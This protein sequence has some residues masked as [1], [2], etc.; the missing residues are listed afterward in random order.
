MRNRPAR[1]LIFLAL[2]AAALPLAA[3]SRRGFSLAVVVD[4]CEVP[5]YEHRGRIY[6][7][8]LRGR[9]FSLRVSNPT[10]ERVAVALSVDGR[11]VIDAGRT[12]ALAAAPTGP[13]VPAPAG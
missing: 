7:E 12:T 5:E 9:D 8:A 10:A 11:N 6:V 1:T 4:G 3:A 2:F 13:A